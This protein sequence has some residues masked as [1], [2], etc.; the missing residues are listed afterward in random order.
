MEQDTELTAMASIVEILGQLSEQARVRVLR[1]AVQ[2]FMLSGSSASTVDLVDGGESAAEAFP[3]FAS[4]FDAANPSSGATRA[5][6]AAY[7]LQVCRGQPE[8]DGQSVNNELKNLG[9][10]SKN[11]TADLSS[12]MN[13]TPRLAMQLR[14]SGRSQQARK[15][16]KLT[17]EGVRRFRSLLNGSGASDPTDKGEL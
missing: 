15:A 2:R 5:L 8:F 6:A 10:P 12:L 3:D 1:Y 17:I 16:Y 9:H 14:K 11:I 13:Q 4:L 7:W